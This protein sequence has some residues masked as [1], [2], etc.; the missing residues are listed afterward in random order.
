[1]NNTDVFKGNAH[2]ERTD[3]AWHHYAWTYDGRELVCLKDGVVLSR[4]AYP[5]T[6]G[7]GWSES[8]LNSFF[9]CTSSGVNQFVGSLDEYRFERRGRSAEWIKACY[10]NQKSG[11]V[12]AKVGPTAYRGLAIVV[13]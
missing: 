1:M 11:S 10:D 6:L 13:R 8:M 2:I 12:F 9:A 4:L 7:V 5:F 3:D